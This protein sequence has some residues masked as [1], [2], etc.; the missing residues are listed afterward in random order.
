MPQPRP[1]EESALTRLARL[2]SG[3][4]RR[5]RNPLESIMLHVALLEEELQRPGEDRQVVMTSS[6]AEVKTSLARIHDLVENYLSLVRLI[7]LQRELVDLGALVQA[8]A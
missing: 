8:F 6:L 4:S 3:S 7:E 5:I 2:A 1:A